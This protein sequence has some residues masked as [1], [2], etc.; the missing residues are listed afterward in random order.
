MANYKKM[1]SILC[2][3]VSEAIDATPERAKELLQEALFEAEDIYIQTCREDSGEDI[4][5]QSDDG[6]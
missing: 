5:S 4:R 6:A 2:G 1:Y 3:A